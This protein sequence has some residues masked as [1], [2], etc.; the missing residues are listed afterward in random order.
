MVFHCDRCDYAAGSR[1]Q[2]ALHAFRVHGYQ[3][4][5]CSLI[6]GVHCPICLQIFHSRPKVIRHIEE[7]SARCKAVLVHKFAPLPPHIVAGLDEA[8]AANARQLSRR[9]RSRHHSDSLMSRLH[10]P[11]CREA[12]AV[13]ISHASLLKTQAANITMQ[14]FAN[15]AS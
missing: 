15:I 9:G 5:A 2:L 6:D 12:Y 10:G 8:D 11:L 4:A 7:Q 13:G 3:R 1:Q 14:M